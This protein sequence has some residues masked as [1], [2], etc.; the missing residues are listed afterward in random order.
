MR[1]QRLFPIC[2][3]VVDR[4]P[5]NPKTLGLVDFLRG[6]GKVGPIHI[7]LVSGNWKVCD[8][9]HRILAYKL[10]GRT[11]IEARYGMS[12]DDVVNDLSF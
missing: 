6:G 11:M 12:S 2:S 8:G 7:Q 1:V 3:L 9:R 10:L 4:S 5:I